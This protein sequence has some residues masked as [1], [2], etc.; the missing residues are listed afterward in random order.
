MTSTSG[1]FGKI[2]ATWTSHSKLAK[3]QAS[4][5]IIR[6]FKWAGILIA[7]T[8][9]PL[10]VAN[11]FFADLNDS[12]YSLGHTSQ[13][14]LALAALA[15]GAK[16]HW[17]ESVS[18]FNLAVSGSAKLTLLT[19]LLQ[20]AALRQ[21]R[22]LGRTSLATLYIPVVLTALGFASTV[23]LATYLTHG[24]EVDIATPQASDFL[25]L[26]LCVAVPMTIGAFFRHY[27]EN[28]SVSG[29]RDSLKSIRIYAA[30]LTATTLLGIAVFWLV[31]VIRPDF[32]HS[33]PATVEVTPQH[34]YLYLF[35]AIL[36]F[37]LNLPALVIGTLSILTGASL[38]A[39]VFSTIEFPSF[40]TG[41]INYVCDISN[42]GC[43]ATTHSISD[44]AGLLTLAN[45]FSLA[46]R[47]TY[48]A[49]FLFTIGL[50]MALSSSF[51]AKSA[52]AE[53]PLRKRVFRNLISY[54]LVAGYFIWLV[55]AEFSMTEQPTSK[56]QTNLNHGGGSIGLA[57]GTLFAI[58]AIFAFIAGMA[59]GEKA[60]AG[61]PT[62]FPHIAK[63]FRVEPRSYTESQGG[64]RAFGLITTT[65]LSLTIVLSLGCATY[66][67]V[68]AKNHGPKF[69]ASKVQT[70][71]EKGDTAGFK[72][73][74]GNPKDL[75]WLNKKI[76]AKALPASTSPSA[77]DITNDLKKPYTTGQLDAVLTYSIGGPNSKVK[78]PLPMDGTT[79]S[80]FHIK[81]NKTHDADYLTK[82]NFTYDAQPV[83]LQITAGEFAP[84][85]LIKKL[86]VND[87]KA[88][89]GTFNTVPGKYNIVL[90]GY[91]LI[92]PTNIV[93]N[94]TST[95]ASATVG[96]DA[97]IPD[98]L[99]SLMTTKFTKAVKGK[100]KIRPT[101]TS[102]GSTCADNYTILA[103]RKLI[104][105]KNLTRFDSV[106]YS[107]VHATKLECD[108]GSNTLTSASSVERTYSCS[109]TIT[110]T[111]K[112]N[113][114]AVYAQ[115][116]PI[117]RDVPQYTT[118]RYDACPLNE[119]NYC[120]EY[121]QVYTGSITEFVGYKRG[122]LLT[123]AKTAKGTFKTKV[124]TEIYITGSVDGKGKFT[125]SQN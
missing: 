19:V 107:N 112:A 89:L 1:I 34:F 121:R 13:I 113:K 93:L 95:K 85:S 69:F 51:A 41:F 60:K 71:L 23:F 3:E 86:K 81:F 123:P 98:K 10:V 68:Y 32:L 61:L 54:S 106:A 53:E 77:I 33:Q 79:A 26:L 4:D 94:T 46:K 16:I 72:K 58:A 102:F 70:A 78:Y 37:A 97:N 9:I 48:V 80:L 42:L 73:L 119:Y 92:A 111:M 40:L 84:S 64:W 2:S 105:G 30:L 49:I 18:D 44:S 75:P 55:N 6:G 88:K 15:G 11:L 114:A 22:K 45:D 43:V 108:G 57:V 63:V 21:G 82:A 62:A 109:Q 117:Y 24:Y 20:V 66:E 67:L 8:T 65:V 38:A 120:W 103:D 31:E 56:L 122:P 7:V 104:T 39:S 50:L 47:A 59:T 74:T 99:N 125:V 115:G 110:F 52:V 83:H 5:A 116:D 29:F 90:P 17:I 101:K 12:T 124:T 76:M 27:S 87:T 28:D 35:G 91:R 36:A 14:G 96:S 100:C 25:R 118:E